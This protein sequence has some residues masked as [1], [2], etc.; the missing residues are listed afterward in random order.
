M[1]IFIFHNLHEQCI[2]FLKLKEMLMKSIMNANTSSSHSPSITNTSHLPSITNI[3][4]S[5]SNTLLNDDVDKIINI[6]DAIKDFTNALDDSFKESK[7]S[8]LNLYRRLLSK[9]DIADKKEVLRFVNP[10]VKFISTYKETITNGDIV[11]IPQGTHIPYSNSVKFYIDVQK[12]IYKGDNNVKSAIKGHLINIS[13][14]IQPSLLENDDVKEFINNNSTPATA[15]MTNIFT[16]VMQHVQNMDIKEGDNPQALLE[17]LVQSDFVKN[18]FS[19]L[20]SNDALQ[21]GN[22]DMGSMI[23]TISSLTNQIFTKE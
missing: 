1:K 14:L 2:S 12:F 20:T 17:N 11:T 19:Q 7:N 15:A 10:F 3:S 9:T 8:P 22:V 6:L 5:P 16:D 13:V 21:D 4:H 23:K 18:M